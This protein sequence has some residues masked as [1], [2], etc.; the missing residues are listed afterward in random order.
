MTI[1]IWYKHPN[2]P[3][4]VVDRAANPKEAAYLLREYRMAYGPRAV[5]WAGTR[6]SRNSDGTEKTKDDHLSLR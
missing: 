1:S 2:M 3:P 6:D 4:E 5:L